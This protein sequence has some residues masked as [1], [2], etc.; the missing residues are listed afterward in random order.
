MR[1]VKT[2]FL[3]SKYWYRVPRP[4]PAAAQMWLMLAAW[5][6][7]SAKTRLAQERIWRARS[8]DRM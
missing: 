2:A 5:N 4:M 7:R 8:S 3:F 1:A 6:P